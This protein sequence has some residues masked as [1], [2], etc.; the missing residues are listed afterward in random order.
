MTDACTPANAD[1]PVICLRLAADPAIHLRLVDSPEAVADFGALI[2]GPPGPPGTTTWADLD[3]KPPAIAA[4]STP[5]EARQAI[6]AVA[7]DDGRLSDA[8]PPTVHTHPIAAVQG[9]PE[10][11]DA[12]A[13]PPLTVI[14]G[15]SFF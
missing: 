3:G 5:A 12:L 11:L 10:A 14:D 15:G 8:R 1:E 13:A 4:G 2:P 7:D 6:G 9:L